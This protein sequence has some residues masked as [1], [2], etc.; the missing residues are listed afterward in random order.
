MIP[1]GFHKTKIILTVAGREPVELSGQDF[2]FG[3]RDRT[4][5]HGKPLALAGEVTLTGG[6]KVSPKAVRQ[7]Q[8]E[9]QPPT[10]NRAQRR[11][12]AQGKPQGYRGQGK[13]SA[14]QKGRR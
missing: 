14:R 4:A 2:S 10:G 1:P 13:A 8:N 9:L 12:Q 3:M 5:D 11:A 6:L 7:L